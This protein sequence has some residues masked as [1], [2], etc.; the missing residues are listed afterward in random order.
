MPSPSTADH[1]LSNRR[2]QISPVYT[3]VLRYS[4][5]HKN[6][7]PYRRDEANSPAVPPYLTWPNGGVWPYRSADVRS[8]KVV[9][10]LP[11]LITGDEPGRNY[12]NYE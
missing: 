1:L 8:A 12:W 7:R 2:S 5:E 4:R 11:S 10:N 3:N 9:F 6:P